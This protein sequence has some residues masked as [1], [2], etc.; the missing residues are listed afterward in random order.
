MARLELTVTPAQSGR[1]VRSLLKRE[2]GLSTSLTG[3]L[4]RTETGLTVNGQRVF[5]NYILQPGDRLAVDLDAAEKPTGIA[6]IPMELDIPYEDEH[7]LV[8]SK[9]APLACIPSSLAPGEPTLAAGLMHHLGDGA[10]VHLVNRLDRGTTGL[11]AAAKN[12]WVH[13]RLRR[14]LHTGDF[15][16]TYLAVCVGAPDPEKGTVTLP[17]GRAPGSAIR[18]Q[19][20]PAGQAAVTD[21]RVLEERGGF[22]LVELTPR[23]G[24]TH[25]IRVHMAALGCPLAGDWLY[26]TED[27]ALIG[28][29]ALHAARLELTHP[30]TG[31]ALRFTAPLPEDI[32]HLLEQ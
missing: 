28:R 20:D 22:A 4:K 1:D 23:T 15:R 3:R 24:R 25:Q 13:D 19:V 9:S 14:Q 5:T 29:P 17:I 8:V 30:V 6:P 2:L 11:L 32:K 21:Y 27:R 26:G 10:S 31:Q 16:R 18:R 12:A 7:L